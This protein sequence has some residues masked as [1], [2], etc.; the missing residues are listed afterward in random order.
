MHRYARYC[1]IVRGRLLI[2]QQKQSVNIRDLSSGG[3]GPLKNRI[4]PVDIAIALLCSFK[5]SH[6]TVFSTCQIQPEIET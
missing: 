4:E 3:R 6:P 2:D 1:N 5:S